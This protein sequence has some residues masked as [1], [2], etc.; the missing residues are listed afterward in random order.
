MSHGGRGR[1]MNFNDDKNQN[2]LIFYR[3]EEIRTK[4][5]NDLSNDI[6]LLLH[7]CEQQ[8]YNDWP[9]MCEGGKNTIQ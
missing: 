8:R 1:K 5:I 6:D 7:R 3:H 2:W 9:A 4:K